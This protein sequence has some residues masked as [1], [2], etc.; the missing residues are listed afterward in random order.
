[1]AEFEERVRRLQKDSS[2]ERSDK[3]VSDPESVP[4]A[5]PVQDTLTHDPDPY[6]SQIQPKTESSEYH[7]LQKM[8]RQLEEQKAKF[9]Q[10]KADQSATL[11]KEREERIQLVNKL[12]DTEKELKSVKSENEAL[13]S[14]CEGLSTYNQ[15][16]VE[17]KSHLA[18]LLSDAEQRVQGSESATSLQQM[19]KELRDLQQ[20]CDE[21]VCEL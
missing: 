15:T 9:E 13:T 20:F 1:V 10:V 19:E 18:K 16:L 11:Q 2:E 4:S 5:R 7:D 14:R 3:S 6:S 17:E 8:K 21:Q 12:G